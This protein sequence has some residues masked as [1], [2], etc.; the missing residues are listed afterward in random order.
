[1]RALLAVMLLGCGS[2]PAVV[3]DAGGDMARLA[4]RDL[5][6]PA[7]DLARADD[8]ATEDLAQDE[9]LAQVTADMSHADL[10]TKPPAD[11]ATCNTLGQA[12]TS[13][14]DPTGSCCVQFPALACLASQFNGFK[15]CCAI[16]GAGQEPH[17]ATDNDC[18]A[19]N[20]PVYCK[21]VS[22]GNLCCFKDAGGIEH[23]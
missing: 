3:T 10:T 6:Y 5:S 15:R 2:N 21:P 19:S 16:A 7:V 17:C 22:T 23:C 12:C 1:M 11:L 14:G 4:P 20:R 18:C 13:L 9:D 8:L